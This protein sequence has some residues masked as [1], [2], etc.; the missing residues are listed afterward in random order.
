MDRKTSYYTAYGM[1]IESEFDL[2]EFAVTESSS[3]S[4]IIIRRG[5]LKP[6]AESVGG[7]EKRRINSEP[8][9]CRL[10][11]ESIGTFV[12]RDG[13]IITCDLDDEEISTKKVFRRI[14]ENQIMAVLLFQRKL[15]VLHGSA[16]VIDGKAT[17]FLGPRTAG[18]STTAAAFYNEGHS[19]LGDDVIAIDFADG[20]PEV[21]PG[22]PQI[23]LSP[24]AVEGIGLEHTKQPAH[25]WGPDKRYQDVESVGAS[26]PL[27]VFY[28][29]QEGREFKSV[30]LSGREPFLHLMTH[31]YAQGLLSES[32]LTTEHFEQCSSVL[33][34]IPFNRLERPKT[35]DALPEL[36]EF[37]NEDIRCE[38]EKKR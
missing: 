12:V 28:L 19:V 16:V 27:G 32:A 2:P 29:L 35:L 1:T 30:R 18:K 3:S 21:V 25:D 36:V 4:D 17:V 7:P 6:V 22:V 8:G 5:S 31:T 13:R 14:V 10:T 38:Y 23:R 11:Y 34:A 24:D 20:V 15:L 33:E 37:V 9:R 26:V